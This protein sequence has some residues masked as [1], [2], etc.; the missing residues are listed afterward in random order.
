MIF[1]LLVATAITGHS[2]NI[3]DT[4]RQF[5]LPNTPLPNVQQFPS[6]CVPTAAIAH[7]ATWLKAQKEKWIFAAHDSAEN[8]AHVMNPMFNYNLSHVPGYPAGSAPSIILKHFADQGAIDM[9]ALPYSSDTTI[10]PYHLRWLALK[11]RG[12][13]VLGTSSISTAQQWLRQGL[14]VIGL[15]RPGTGPNSHCV[16]IYGYD[17]DYD[18]GDGYIGA[19]KFQDSNPD[20]LKITPYQG[21]HRMWSFYTIVPEENTL[22]D[23]AVAM[24]SNLFYGPGKYQ[25]PDSCLRIKFAFIK[26]ADTL[27]AVEFSSWPMASSYLFPVDDFRNADEAEELIV[28]ATYQVWLYNRTEQPF[29]IAIDSLISLSANGQKTVLSFTGELSETILDSVVLNPTL[30]NREFYARYTAK[31]R[32]KVLSVSENK[33]L[34]MTVY[35]NPVASG[36]TLR[37]VWP[38]QQIHSLSILSLTG[39]LIHYLPISGESE[40]SWSNN[41]PPGMYILHLQN[42]DGKQAATKFVVY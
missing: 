41:L 22:P 16:F 21:P 36:N 3:A 34:E 30:I 11:E 28:T 4:L 14:P 5:E 27:R 39:Q 10:A 1:W 20:W 38:K 6:L 25:I 7:L 26:G 35:P 17:S 8:W 31:T 24:K 2:Q 42:N 18:F 23:Y 32:L 9:A 13:T 29:H 19:W 12:G 37:V 33:R 15:F 40:F